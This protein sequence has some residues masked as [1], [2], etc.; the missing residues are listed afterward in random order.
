MSEK[1]EL[2]DPFIKYLKS[3]GLKFIRKNW[4]NHNR[5]GDDGHPDFII[6]LNMGTTLFIEFKTQ[7]KYS[8][9]DNGLSK[10]QIEWEEYLAR[11]LHNYLLTYKV[12]FAINF[13]EIFLRNKEDE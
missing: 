5:Q 10:K 2:H 6:F 9:K 12:A 7:R 11:K 1:T 8:S 13:V 4:N 3:K